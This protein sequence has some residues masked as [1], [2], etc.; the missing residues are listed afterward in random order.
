[1]YCLREATGR[2]DA[3]NSLTWADVFASNLD[4]LFQTALLLVADPDEAENTL[5]KAIGDL[6]MSKPP[7]QD[8]IATVTRYIVVNSVPIKKPLS[9]VPITTVRRMLH[10]ALSPILRLTNAP[11]VCFVLLILLGYATSSCAQILGLEEHVVRM[12]LHLA[13]LQLRSAVMITPRSIERITVR[14]Q[15]SSRVPL[16]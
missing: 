12:L 2:R 16:F 15:D 9:S 6:D 11:R 7:A 14:K 8:A 4:R 3:G 1:M 13:L 10:P 5:R